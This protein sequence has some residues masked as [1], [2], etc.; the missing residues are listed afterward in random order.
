MP[1][2]DFEAGMG[3]HSKQINADITNYTD[4]IPEIQISEV[5]ADVKT[6]R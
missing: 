3:P 6:A 5:R 1:I 2:E 4:L